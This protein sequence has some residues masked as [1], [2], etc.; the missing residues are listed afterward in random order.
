MLLNG[1][2]A[3]DEWKDA[4]PL[5]AGDA[6]GLL[7]KQDRQYLYVAIRF[8]EGLRHSGGE[9]FVLDQ[10]GVLASYHV[11]SALGRREWKGSTW[12]DYEWQP[13][14][15]SANVIQT[16]A[17]NGKMKVLGPEG[18]EY[19]IRKDHFHGKR[20]RLRVELLRPAAR[21]PESEQDAPEWISVRF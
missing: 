4:R 3:P 11:S 1:D 21:I 6:Y 8:P 10:S 17:E 13:R 19:Q 18:L 14:T 20:L 15:W 12:T 5:E 2:L 7:V 9:L 16:I